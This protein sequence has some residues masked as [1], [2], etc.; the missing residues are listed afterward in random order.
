[1][2]PVQKCLRYVYTCVCKAFLFLTENGQLLNINVFNIY[3]TDGVQ[4]PEFPHVAPSDRLKAGHKW[5][6]ST[7]TAFT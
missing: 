2:L 7:E 5:S 4:H 3:V 6:S 1:M